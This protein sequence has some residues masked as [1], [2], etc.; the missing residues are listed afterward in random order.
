MVFCR[1]RWNSGGSSAAGL[2]PYFSASLIIASCTMSSAL[3]WFCTAYSACLYARRST[4]PKNR[5]SSFGLARLIA[6]LQCGMVADYAGKAPRTTVSGVLWGFTGM[7]HA[8]RRRVALLVLPG[9]N[10]QVRIGDLDAAR[11]ERL[12][13]AA[14]KFAAHA[15]LL[16]RDNLEAAA[17]YHGGIRPVVHTGDI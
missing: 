15:P 16:Q 6:P 10:G 12:F 8:Q 17:Q 2:S 7:E 13:Q 5:D 9:I 3:C 1:M 14:Q 11:V 4:L